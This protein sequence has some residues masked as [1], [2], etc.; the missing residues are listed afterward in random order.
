MSK[1]EAAVTSYTQWRDCHIRLSYKSARTDYFLLL[2]TDKYVSLLLCFKRTSIRPCFWSINIQHSGVF[3]R[4]IICYGFWTPV[5]FIKYENFLDIGFIGVKC[6]LCIII[7]IIIGA[8]GPSHQYTII[9]H[10]SQS[11]TI[12]CTVSSIDCLLPRTGI[13][14][15]PM[16]IQFTSS[17]AFEYRNLH[18]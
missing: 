9:P 12:T 17:F 18:I 10:N 16:S 14:Y 15:C 8:S 7:I 11:P 5:A 2:V 3:T 6:A 4:S 13:G 1:N